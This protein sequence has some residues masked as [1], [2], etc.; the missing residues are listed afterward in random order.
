MFRRVL[1]LVQQ[2]LLCFFTHRSRYSNSPLLLPCRGSVIRLRM[3]MPES[4]SCMSAY[5]Q[6]Q[7]F[8]SS[9]NNA[10][11]KVL[12][13]GL[14]RPAISINAFDVFFGF[15]YGMQLT[16]SN[17]TL[18]AATDTLKGS[19]AVHKH[20]SADTIRYICYDLASQDT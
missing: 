9:S 16:L 11:H 12:S 10:Q 3:I 14:K 18:K 15:M 19:P 5:Q 4:S 8:Q 6:S 17:I 13:N 2:H 1:A 20:I 7:T